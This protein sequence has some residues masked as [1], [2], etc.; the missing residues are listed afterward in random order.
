MTT[1]ILELQAILHRIETIE[2][3][4]R[5]LK[6]AAFVCALAAIALFGACGLRSRDAVEAERFAVRDKQ[7]RVRVEIAMSYDFPNGNPVIRLLDEK[8][9]E[10]TTLGA[11]V[12][13]IRDEKGTVGAT[14]LDDTLQFGKG[15]AAARLEGGEHGG[16][17]WLFGSPAGGNIL[18]NSDLSSIEVSDSQGY[19]ADLGKSN[20]FTD[21]TGQTRQTSAASLVMSGKDDKV[22]WSAP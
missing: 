12:L 1:D 10:L 17:L 4:I 14:L 13:E 20:L 11:G 7:G 19:R 3:Q 5:H 16:M 9:K 8:G 15:G 2:T 6:R 21:K 22:L 18:L